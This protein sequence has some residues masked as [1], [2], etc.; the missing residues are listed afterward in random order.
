MSGKSLVKRFAVCYNRAVSETGRLLGVD[1]GLKRVGLAVCDGT[2]TL[3]SPLGVYRTKSMRDTID[4][5]AAL[6]TRE[7]V[8]GIVVGLPLNLDGTESVQSGRVRA[9]SRNLE[10][11]AGLPVALV[12]ERLTTV[13][14]DELLVEAGVKKRARR[15]GI[16]DS[17]AAKIILQSYI[18]GDK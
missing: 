9:F 3:A 14:A 13:E 17:L 7:E 18:D 12:D 10:R 4:Y 6:A 11:V 1:F 8:C 5:V 16:V 15:D 2:R